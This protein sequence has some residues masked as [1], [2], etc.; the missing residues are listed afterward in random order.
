M[1]LASENVAQDEIR[2][3]NEE[4]D[5]IAMILRTLTAFSQ[6]RKPR[7]EQV[8][9]NALITDLVKL[10]KDSMAERANISIH[11][12]LDPAI[13]KPVS[14]KDGLKQVL[15]NLMKNAAEAMPGGGNIY[16]STRRISADLRRD[17]AEAGEHAHSYVEIVCRDDGPG[18]AEEIKE[19]LFEPFVTSKKEGHSGVGLSIAFQTI[20]ALGG[21]LTCESEEGEGTIFNI[22]LPVKENP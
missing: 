4:I 5:R 2:I 9:I 21:I 7:I 15:I 16:L 18:I 20:K 14:E 17:T 19:R 12:D 8:D 22:S 3:I 6:N 1:K 13:P 11:T 10:T